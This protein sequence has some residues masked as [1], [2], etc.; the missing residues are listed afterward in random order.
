[1]MNKVLMQEK[2]IKACV[3]SGAFE[4]CEIILISKA[5]NS[6]FKAFMSLRT[7]TGSD[8]RPEKQRGG[9]RYF[10]SID[11]AYSYAEKLGFKSATL[12]SLD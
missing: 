3:A 2:E 8:V 6:E 12:V 10:K 5:H 11:S 4:S 9:Q 7:V 1:M